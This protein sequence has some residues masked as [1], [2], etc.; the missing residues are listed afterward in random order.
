MNRK[1]TLTKK[2]IKYVGKK[3]E[4]ANMDFMM[5]NAGGLE[6]LSHLDITSLTGIGIE[7]RKKYSEYKQKS[8][9]KNRSALI[10]NISIV[11]FKV[12]HMNNYGAH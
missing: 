11:Y 12:R 3:I 6:K 5:K 9:L 8:K 7:H 2:Q 1:E 4:K 10:F